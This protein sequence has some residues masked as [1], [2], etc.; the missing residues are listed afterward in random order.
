M[1]EDSTKTKGKS[2]VLKERQTRAMGE[3]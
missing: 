2:L 3:T 1:E